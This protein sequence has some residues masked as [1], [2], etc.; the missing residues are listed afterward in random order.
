MYS[1]VQYNQ[2]ACWLHTDYALAASS[3]IKVERANRA[4][5]LATKSHPS[6]LRIKRATRVLHVY[7]TFISYEYYLPV[8]ASKDDT[9]FRLEEQIKRVQQGQ[10]Q[11]LVVSAR[12]LQ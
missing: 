7:F 10:Q 2:K 9:Q 6:L 1:T 12:V 4:S 11:Q 3:R 5:F 8:Q